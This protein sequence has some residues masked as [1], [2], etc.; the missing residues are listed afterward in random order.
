MN[1]RTFPFLARWLLTRLAVKR[2]SLSLIGDMYEEYAVCISHQRWIQRQQWLFTEIMLPLISFLRNHFL[3]RRGMLSN[4]FK[5]SFRNLKRSPGY[6]TINIVGLA[7]GMAACMLIFLWVQDELSFDRFH[8]HHKQI[9]RII[10]HRDG[11]WSSSTPFS[12]PRTLKKDFPE[13]EQVSRFRNQSAYV[14]YDDKAF[15][16]EIGFIDPDFIDMFS[17]SILSGNKE[18]PIETESQVIITQSAAI[19]YFGQDDPIGQVL[20]LDNDTDVTV[21][22]VVQDPP[23]NS[24]M[25]FTILTNFKAVGQRMDLSWWTGCNAY[26]R[27]SEQSIPADVI[28]KIDGTTMKY[29][30]RIKNNQINESL[31]P[32]TRM[33]L[34]GLNKLGPIL[35]VV[36]FSIIAAVVLIIACIN[37]INLSTAQASKRA[38]EIGLR[39]TVGASRGS[40]VRQLYGETLVLSFLA[41]FIAIIMVAICLPGFNQ[42]AAKEITLLDAGKLPVLLGLFTIAL[43]TGLV[44]G[45]YPALLLSRYRPIQVLRDG[46][47]KGARNPRLRRILVIFQFTAAIILISSTL[48]IQR[49][50]HYVQNKDL[51]FQKT[52]IV[53]LNINNT[54]RPN[55]ESFKNRLRQNTTIVSVTSANTTPNQIRNINPFYWEGRSPDESETLNFTTVDHDY[56]K[57]FGLEMAE[58]RAFAK[59]FASDS[60]RENPGYIIN[61]AAVAHTGLTDP[62]GK[63]FSIWNAEGRVVGVVKDFH[64]R[65]LHDVI[66][67]VIFLCS[68]NWQHYWVFISIDPSQRREAMTAIESTWDE[69]APDYPCDMEFLEDIDRE[70]YAEDGRIA[71]LFNA[72]TYL[73]IFISC[74][75]LL[76][77]AAFLAEQRTK[78]IGIRK[79]LGASTFNISQLMSREFILLLGISNLLSWPVA[80]FAMQRMMTAWA[81]RE[82]IAWWIFAGSGA[83]AILIALA[84]VSYQS[85]KAARSNPVDALKYE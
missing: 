43:L 21:T 10:Q 26:V 52:D 55:L 58:G 4:Y 23:K 27:L 24:S 5:I 60:D 13:I 73:A 40:I 35:Y 51:G 19:K 2:N 1:N 74:L 32:L 29:D 71:S 18:T 11:G 37:F 76:G 72:F 62:I 25:Q 78:E 65:S 49:Q 31:Q 20:N 44:S 45:S 3:W 66:K 17:F 85:I 54:L 7:V 64:S 68:N 59:E 82:T 16:E 28:Q 9:Y 57:T 22:A 48:I 41:F 80:W 33:H 38:R 53:R 67:P 6:T 79:A 61:E 50:M 56:F 39:K 83:I 84:T 14:K 81:Y 34:Y 42:M 36:L 46:A 30:Q 8:Q 12:L 47:S 75:G 69:M 77:L 15:Y 70:R 63:M